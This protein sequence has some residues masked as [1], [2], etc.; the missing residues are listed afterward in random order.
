MKIRRSARTILAILLLLTVFTSFT[1]WHNKAP[2]NLSEQDQQVLIKKL[3][4]KNPGLLF[5]VENLNHEDST[6]AF[7]AIGPAPEYVWPQRLYRASYSDPLARQSQPAGTEVLI[8][9]RSIEDFLFLLH[10][11][12]KQAPGTL[13]TVNFEDYQAISEP[14]LTISF[15]LLVSLFVGITGL[16]VIRHFNR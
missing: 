13:T 2:G 12:E 6:L 16:I 7:Y 10:E 4:L 3:T 11:A 8:R 1:V 9:Y 14:P 5:F 15:R